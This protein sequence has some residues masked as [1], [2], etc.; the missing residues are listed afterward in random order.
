MFYDYHNME[1]VKDVLP[2]QPRVGDIFVWHGG[3]FRRLLGGARVDDKDGVII[4]KFYE[5][6]ASRRDV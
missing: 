1:F 4:S 3:R 2:S 5:A 6:S